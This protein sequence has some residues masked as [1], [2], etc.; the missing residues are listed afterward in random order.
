MHAAT[1]VRAT[2]LRHGLY[3]DWEV[4]GWVGSYRAITGG[5]M[6]AGTDVVPRLTGLPARTVAQHLRAH[7][8]D[9]AHL[10]G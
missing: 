6:A 2:V 9:W 10:R 3:A 1:G 4:E 7:P 5:E 8:E